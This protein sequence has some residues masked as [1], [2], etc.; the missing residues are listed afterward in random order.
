MFI[1]THQNHSLLLAADSGI[2][3]DAQQQTTLDGTD[4]HQ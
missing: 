4:N 2:L 1:I 3:T